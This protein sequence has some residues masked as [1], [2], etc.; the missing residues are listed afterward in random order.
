MSSYYVYYVNSATLSNWVQLAKD[1]TGNSN[2]PATIAAAIADFMLPRGLETPDEYAIATDVFKGAIPDNYFDDGSW[3][4]DWNEAQD[5]V[6]NLLLYLIK[7][8][9]FQLN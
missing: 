3:N 5:Q 8:P 7:L 2:N 6:R 9:A 1:L 4:L